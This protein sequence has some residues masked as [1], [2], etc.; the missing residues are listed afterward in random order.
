MKNLTE[1]QKTI[2][3]EITN[4][5]IKT[6]EE[7]KNK[8]KGSLFDINGLLG[9]READIEERYQIERNNEFYDQILQTKI[10]EDMDV[11]NIDLRQ[12]G[13]R[14]WQPSTWASWV[15]GFVIDTI[16]NFE[17]D[18]HFGKNIKVDYI[19]IKKTK[20]FESGISDIEEY[21]NNHKIGWKN[22][23]YSNI[24]SFATHKEIINNI[25]ELINKTSL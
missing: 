21:E 18:Y 6:N 19:L 14:A 22:Y 24:K 25:K 9:Q 15:R 3:A 12:L 20:S 10:Q 13:L 4:E 17:R 5:F 23:R 11:L 16:E 2:I 1:K 7:N 8:P